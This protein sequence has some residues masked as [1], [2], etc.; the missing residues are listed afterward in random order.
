MILYFMGWGGGR[1]R[2]QRRVLQEVKLD[3]VQSFAAS[4]LI[5]ITA[6]QKR[7]REKEQSVGVLLP[8]NSPTPQT[9]NSDVLRPIRPYAKRSKCKF[10]KTHFVTL[11]TLAHFGDAQSKMIA[12]LIC[13]AF[14]VFINTRKMRRRRRLAYS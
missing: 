10:S 7:A 4:P 5:I 3:L 12:P 11:E 9:N 6:R 1:G 2:T 8:S 14:I 13:V